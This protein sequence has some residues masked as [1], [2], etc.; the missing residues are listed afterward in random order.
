ML[1]LTLGKIDDNLNVRGI[2]RQ[3]EYHNTTT[4]MNFSCQK[5]GYSWITTLKAIRKGQGCKKCSD[6][7]KRVSSET[8][9]NVL[10]KKN[11]KLL[12]NY[13]DTKTKVELLCLIDGHT[14]ESNAHQIKQ[15]KG[16]SV[17]ARSDGL[18]NADFDYRIQDRSITRESDYL[19]AKEKILMSCDV[20][21]N[22]W[23][24]TA[25]TILKGSGCPAC[26]ITGF[27]ESLDGYVYFAR[28]LV[29]D[30]YYYKIGI[31]NRDP[32][33]RLKSSHSTWEVLA[34]VKLKGESCRLLER[35]LLQR[36]SHIKTEK[37]KGI[38]KNGYTEIFKP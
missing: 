25:N 9:F 38:I 11:I 21:S 22:K 5:C 32:A 18:T 36:Y 16:C 28:I 6:E 1:K 26:A 29:E 4:K 10:E 2:L 14:W 30:E 12:T 13:V 17:C 8:F 34:K 37:L 19:S 35:W 7:N 15:G 31:T 24:A 23:K 27:K 3:S 20:C 33:A